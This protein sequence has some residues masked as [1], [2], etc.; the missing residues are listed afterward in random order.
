MSTA[1]S[2]RRPVRSAHSSETARP[3]A[4]SAAAAVSPMRNGV[5]R[6]GSAPP[7][8]AT[9]RARS[10]RQPAIGRIVPRA[11]WLMAEVY[12]GALLRCPGD[13]GSRRRGR[14][15]SGGRARRRRVRRLPHRTLLE[16][17]EEVQHVLLLLLAEAVE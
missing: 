9:V 6:I 1:T 16:R 17:P 4:A 10:S 3:T 11:S 12:S 7:V 13:F 2:W 15:P 8:I 5:G 14:G